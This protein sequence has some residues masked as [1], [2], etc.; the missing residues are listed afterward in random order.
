[1][2]CE[3]D[4]K[5]PLDLTFMDCLTSPTGKEGLSQEEAS[6][7]VAAMAPLTG[8]STRIRSKTK[9]KARVFPDAISPS[10]E[11]L[12][13]VTLRKTRA[14]KKGAVINDTE[15]SSSNLLSSD[16]DR[17]SERGI[18]GKENAPSKSF[19]GKAR[20][21]DSV[22]ISSEEEDAGADFAPTDLRIMG[23]MNVGSLGLD[24][25]ADVERMRAKSRNLQ[26]GISGKMRKDLERAKEV[27][28][29]L[30]FK[31]EAAGD[32]AYLRIKNKVNSA[33]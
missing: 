21:E 12:P 15:E 26:G 17:S 28:N 14:N 31:A 33:G 7:Q 9:R 2:G 19:K 18:G 24:C 23:A 30:I 22:L 20:K 16:T 8:R 32:P 25:L 6:S 1:M 3:E 5:D 13:A 29:T 4:P 10:G 27:I 11:G